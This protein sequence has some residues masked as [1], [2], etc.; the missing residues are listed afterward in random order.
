VAC[1]FDE[2]WTLL[3]IGLFVGQAFSLQ[4]ALAGLFGI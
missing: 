3:S 1:D 2:A 4:P